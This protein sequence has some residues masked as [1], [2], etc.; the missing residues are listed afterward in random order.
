M[1]WSVCLDRNTVLSCREDIR[2]IVSLLR[3]EKKKRMELSH[4]VGRLFL[5]HIFNTSLAVT[6]VKEYIDSLVHSIQRVNLGGGGGC[7]TTT[8]TNL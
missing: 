3:A 5:P 8:Y 1:G 2:L 7:L 6:V 4:S